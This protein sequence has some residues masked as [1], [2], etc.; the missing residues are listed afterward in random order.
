MQSLSFASITVDE[1]DIPLI[2]EKKINAAVLRL[3]KIHPVISGNKW[4]KLKYY[5]E[6]AKKENK[7]QIITWGGPFSNHII[8]TAAAGKL[9]GFK[10][11]GIIRG[12]EPTH[13]S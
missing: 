3:D 8:A 2:R 9:S 7:E 1:L 12:E 6:K 11:T 5:L 10:T 13:L 4:F